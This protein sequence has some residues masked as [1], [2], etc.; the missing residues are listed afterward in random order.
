MQEVTDP[1]LIARLNSGS[2]DSR[3][4]KAPNPRERR[5]DELDIQGKGLGNQKTAEEIERDRRNEAR[6]NANDRYTQITGMA[7]DYNSAPEVK[8]YR[9]A[10]TEL[11]K[12][13]KTGSGP[14]ADLALTYAFAKAMD[15]ESVVRESE[16]NMVTA[17][18]PWFKAAVENAKKQFGMDGAGNYTPETRDALR[19]QIASA[20]SQRAKIYDARREYFT[21]Q[22]EELGLP[23]NLIVGE[24]DAKPFIPILKK[25][26]EQAR[27]ANLGENDFVRDGVQ[28]HRDPVSG[29][30]TPLITGGPAGYGQSIASQGLSGVNEGIAGVAGLPVDLATGALNL[31]P[32]GINALANTNL[33]TIQNP[34][35]G[36]QWIKDRLGDIGAIGEQPNTTGGQVARRVGESVGAS[37]FPAGMAGS[38]TRGAGQLAVGLGGGAGAAGAQQMFPG[39]QVAE[40][41]G[42]VVGGGATGLGL[43]NQARRGAVRQAEAAVPTVDQL[44]ERAGELYRQAESRGVGAGPSQTQDLAD[45]MRATLTKEGRISPEGRI[46]EVYPKAREGMQLVD[47]YAGKQMNPTQMQAVRKVI[48]DGLTSKDGSERRLAGMLTDNFDGWSMPMAPELAQARGVA[49]RYLTAEQLQTARELAGARAGQFTGSGFENA[50]RTEYRALDRGAIRGSQRFSDDV[51]DAVETVSRGTPASNFARGLGR[52]APTGVVPFGLGSG[53]PGFMAGAATGSPTI[54]GATILGMSALG[55]AGRSA[56]TNL[57]IRNADRAELVARNGGALPEFPLLSQEQFPELYRALAAQAAK[58][59]PNESNR[60]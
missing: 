48:A 4:I 30:E 31:V 27:P 52:L 42:E 7:K 26:D 24:H 41:A 38:L 19:R 10:I 58:Y 6:T 32:R 1:N 56:A 50:L 53:L 17:S 35:L 49:S 5:K 45:A 14:S 29:E 21:N 46:S 55:S 25:F 2:Q 44:K 47:D 15:P 36:S 22:A 39:N 16:Q 3:V 18:Q 13:M 34:L 57:G 23:A 59:I 20:V 33:P 11:A 60:R 40:M 28:W 51:T 54:G 9:V 37:V 8:A 43:L 12:A